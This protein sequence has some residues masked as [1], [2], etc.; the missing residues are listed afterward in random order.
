MAETWNRIIE[1]VLK[2]QTP[3]FL[4]ASR[5]DCMKEVLK[6]CL[7]ILEYALNFFFNIFDNFARTL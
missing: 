1:V 6:N 2:R 4:K 5:I 7:G 3:G